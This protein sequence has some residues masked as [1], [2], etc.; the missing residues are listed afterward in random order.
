MIAAGSQDGRRSRAASAFAGALRL[1]AAPTF[2][3]MALLTYASGGDA[4]MLLCSTGHGMSPLSGMGP[5]Y[6][7]MS[8]FH[9]TPWVN[10]I[11]R[12]RDAAAK[13]A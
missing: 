10:L 6:L 4:A 12:G 11:S 5:M 1:S 2:A 9:S 7:L 13:E 8:A 3:T